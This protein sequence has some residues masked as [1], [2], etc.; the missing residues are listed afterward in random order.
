MF[1]LKCIYLGSSCEPGWTRFARNGACYKYFSSQKS[2]SGA[3]SSCR[4]LGGDLASVTD[5]STN[6]FLTSLTTARAWIGGRR[7][8]DGTWGTWTDGTPWCYTRWY[9]GEPNNNKYAEGSSFDTEDRL[10]INIGIKRFG[11]QPGFWNDLADGR[12]N[13]YICQK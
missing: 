3:H 5:L 6:E 8:S 4:A 10:M 2:W 12:T 13:G 1:T 7:N 11:A 9:P